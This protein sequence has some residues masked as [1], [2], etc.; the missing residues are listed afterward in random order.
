MICGR[1]RRCFG[2]RTGRG[3][4]VD[5]NEFNERL[6]M[7]SVQTGNVRERRMSSVVWGEDVSFCKEGADEKK[8]REGVDDGDD[9]DVFVCGKRKHLHL[10]PGLLLDVQLNRK[11]CPRPPRTAQNTVLQSEQRR[12]SYRVGSVGLEFPHPHTDRATN[13]DPCR[14]SAACSSCWRE[15]GGLGNYLSLHLGNVYSTCLWV[16]DCFC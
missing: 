5:C 3:S 11:G 9:D 13:A 14:F 16:V 6:K 12:G 4:A 15:R 1:V 10:A 7:D 8:P 2:Q